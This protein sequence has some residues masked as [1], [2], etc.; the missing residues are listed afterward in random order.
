MT[1][2]KQERLFKRI[3]HSI[4]HDVRS[5]MLLVGISN[6]YDS[7]TQIRKNL[8]EFI[9]GEPYV[10]GENLL[11]NDPSFKEYCEVLELNSF[12]ERRVEPNK[13]SRSEKVTRWMITSDGDN[14]AVPAAAYS[15][16][17]ASLFNVS[18]FKVLGKTGAP[19]ESSSRSPYNTARI[20]LTLCDKGEM[21]EHDMREFFQL[22][23]F[24]L[25]YH[26]RKLSEFGFI[27]RDLVSH[28]SRKKIFDR[29]INLGKGFVEEFLRP[30]WH[31]CGKISYEQDAYRNVL[32]DYLGDQKR[33]RHDI[34]DALFLLSQPR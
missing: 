22:Y 23:K 30:I 8:L 9:Q 29:I 4:N 26:C 32:N 16:R 6:V 5:A 24:S 34:V 10:N 17:A 28:M 27:E 14:Y 7:V 20:L 33:M 15:I 21:I 13:I 2:R 12:A 25:Q 18:M 19:P 11:P 1:T 31:T 3:M